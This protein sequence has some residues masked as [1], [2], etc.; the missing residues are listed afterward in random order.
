MI[1]YT[2]FFCRFF[3]LLCYI[4]AVVALKSDLQGATHKGSTALYSW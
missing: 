2:L 1:F 4:E 3:S